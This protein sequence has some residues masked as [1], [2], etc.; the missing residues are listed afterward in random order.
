VPPPAHIPARM[1]NEYAYCPRLMYLEWVQG[2]WA[3][4]TETVEGKAAHRRVDRPEGARAKIH[5]RSVELADDE[6]G[7]VA[8][9]DLIESDTRG[10]VRPVDYK[11]GKRPHVSGGAYEP[12]RVQLCVQGLLL[13][14]H[15]YTCDEGVLYFVGSKERVRV[16]FTAPL[17]ARTR[18]LIAELREVVGGGRI[19]PPLV[20]SPKC[21]RCSLVGICLPEETNFLRGANAAPRPLTTSEPNRYPVI[22]QEPRV[23]VRVGG[24]RLKICD[25]D[26]VLATA[27]LPSTSQVILASGAE[28]TAGAIRAC[29]QRDIPIVHQSG[30]GWLYGVTHAS[31]HKN[32]ELR[33]AQFGAAADQAH[34]LPIARRLVADKI[35]NARV[36]LRRNAA[37][38][39]AVLDRLG[40]A[41]GAAEA[42]P[43]TEAL[44]GIEGAA[45]R[46]YFG[47][48]PHALKGAAELREV[49]AANGRTKRPPRDLVN[50]LL[51][52]AYATLTRVWVTTTWAAG[53]DPMLGFYHRPR[54]GKPALALDLMEPFRSVIADSVVLSLINGGEIGPNDGYRRERAVL[55][56][57][58]ARKRFYRAF[59]RRLG[60]Q[61]KHPVFGYACSYR[62]IF[63]IQ[64]RLLGR[65]LFD[66]IPEPPGFVVR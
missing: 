59:E 29:M 22:V 66:E 8:K 9:L 47:A 52:L 15:G 40:D 21:P 30:T 34:V 64:A 11:R 44:L 51:S 23:K 16:R 2:E 19:P 54:Y 31:V 48:L 5:Q 18:Q 4:N 24:E 57:P 6:V 49:F 35:R 45:A 60:E 53:F 58:A 38:V 42:A 55:L 7:V 56:T 61:I 50:A 36:F 63:D 25:G 33:I 10:R 41:A 12:E 14:A 43:D 20:D 65:Y 46:V 17:V 1:L 3:D 39:R 62:R 32:V 26:E 28:I 13:R 27:R 37:P